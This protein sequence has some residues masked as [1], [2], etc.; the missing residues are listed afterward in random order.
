MKTLLNRLNN[1]EIEQQFR[2]FH[3][4]RAS[5]SLIKRSKYC[6]LYPVLMVY[7]DGSTVTVRHS[8]PRAIIKLPVL[9]EDCKTDA[10]RREWLSR[11]KP[12][13]VIKIEEEDSAVQFDS[14]Q[15]LNMIKN[16]SRAH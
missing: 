5:I 10:E 6:R 1:K 15:Y 11:R 8:E 14:K 16:K 3:S 12:K 13:E 9:L 2:Y 4:N 7:P